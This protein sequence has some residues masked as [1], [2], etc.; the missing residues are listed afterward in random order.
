MDRLVHIL[1]LF[2][3]NN[4]HSAKNENPYPDFTTAT[5][6][7]QE[8]GQVFE[9]DQFGLN[10]DLASHHTPRGVAPSRH[11]LTKQRYLEEKRERLLAEATE[12][13]RQHV[14]AEN[15]AI[16]TGF[17]RINRAVRAAI[18]TLKSPLRLIGD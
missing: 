17:G 2:I 5:H 4:T 3:Q 8:I 16:A 1:E 10:P 7:D 9:R 12:R 15:E 6:Q 13:K 11:A 18:K 14:E